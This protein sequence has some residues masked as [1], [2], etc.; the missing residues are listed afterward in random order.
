MK[1]MVVTLA[2]VVA[3]CG[4]G[5]VITEPTDGDTPVTSPDTTTPDTT[6]PDSTIA[7]NPGSTEP[8]TT[9]PVGG[10]A[11]IDS[12][13]PVGWIEGP[14]FVEGSDLLIMESFPIQVRLDV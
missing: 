7:P 10:E 8:P 12:L 9:D 3:A 11:P 14:F 5:E 6:I 1:I 13:P 4:G 2:V